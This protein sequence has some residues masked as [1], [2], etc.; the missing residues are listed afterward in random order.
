MWT[1]C[2]TSPSPIS[3]P[4]RLWSPSQHLRVDTTPEFEH[5]FFNLGITNSTVKD[6]SGKVIGNSDVAGFCPFQD[7]NVRKAIMLAS[8]AVLH[9]ELLYGRREGLLSL[10]PNSYWYNT[11]LTPVSV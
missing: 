9:Q 8:T 1:W 6:A 10:W 5:L 2:P 3:R 4:F 7:V 11:S